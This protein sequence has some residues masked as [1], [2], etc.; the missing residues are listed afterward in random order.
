MAMY[1]SIFSIKKIGIIRIGNPKRPIASG[2]HSVQTRKNHPMKSK[3][4]ISLF[5]NKLLN[6]NHI[7]SGMIGTV[8][9]LYGYRAKNKGRAKLATWNMG[10]TSKLHLAKMRTIGEQ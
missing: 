7:W 6:G 1:M 8:Q 9:V 4:W 10:D 3:S 2:A 5:M